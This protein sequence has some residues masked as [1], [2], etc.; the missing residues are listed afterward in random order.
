[1]PKLMLHGEILP[2]VD[3]DAERKR[4]KFVRSLGGKMVQRE[5]REA[6]ERLHAT[7]RIPLTGVTTWEGLDWHPRYL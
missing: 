6:E 5:L 3:Y 4:K 7:V 2:V 1:M